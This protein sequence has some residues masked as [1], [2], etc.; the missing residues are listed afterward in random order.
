M[1]DKIKIK[2]IEPTKAVETVTP[3]KVKETEYKEGKIYIRSV[4][5]AFTAL[6]QKINWILMLG[7]FLLPWISYAGR[8]AVLFDLEAQKF[9]IFGL[10]IWP[11]DL[12][13]L[14]VLLMIAAYALFLVTTFVG[15]VWC[16]FT[17][18]QTIWTFIF[19]WVE[20]KVEGKVN[21]RKNLDKQPSHF[22]KIWKKGLKHSIWLVISLITSLTFLA[23][24]VPI[25]QL[26]VE[27]FTLNSTGTIY[28]WAV[29]FTFCTYGNAGWM[30]EIMCLHMCPYARFQSAMFDKDTFSVAYDATRGESRGPRSRKA[31]PK[32]L[33]LGDCID[34]NLC[35]QV[36]PTGIDIRDGLQYECINCGA[37][38]D[39]CDDVMDKMGY[40]N[41]LISY[42]TENQLEGKKTN[43]LRSK[44]VGYGSVLIIMSIV[45]GY[46]LM[47]MEQGKLDIIRDRNQL[48]RI[49]SEGMLENVYTLKLLNKT[50]HKLEYTLSFSG[51]DEYTWIGRKKIT[52]EAGEVF[53]LPMSISTDPYNLKKRSL[54]VS[55]VASAITNDGEVLAITAES[56][57]FNEF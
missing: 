36:C 20:E 42:T 16:G 12:V 47:T 7:F 24:F 18:P 44:L 6:R 33:E 8:Q 45:F 19:V 34:C 11:Q 55:F 10:I 50:E 22:N 23:F 5:G 29:F 37:C 14:A 27:F 53:T 38:I 35:V 13:L 9:H 43:I 39:A 30:R 41:K 4:K 57:F 40:E 31:D 1:S 2:V 28:F 17:C 49:S 21:K 3:L 52:V 15:R 46:F 26:Y 54:P 32:E 48:Y 25:K 56:K 51:L